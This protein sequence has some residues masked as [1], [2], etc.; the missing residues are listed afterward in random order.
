MIELQTAS[1]KNQNLNVVKN[2]EKQTLKAFLLCQWTKFW[3]IFF[4]FIL[5][6]PFLIAHFCFS[7]MFFTF[8][9]CHLLK[10]FFLFLSQH[11]S[12]VYIFLTTRIQKI[13]DNWNFELKKTVKSIFQLSPYFF[14]KWLLKKK[15]IKNLFKK[16]FFCWTAWLI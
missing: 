3:L 5:A 8:L 1:D 2:C 14:V 7:F 12:T 4:F 9:C 6:L 13:K 11:L 15:T 10:K 16:F